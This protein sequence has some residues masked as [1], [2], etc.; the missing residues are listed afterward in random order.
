[1]RKHT[2]YIVKASVKIQKQKQLRWGSI[3]SGGGGG[4]QCC[5]NRASSH[6]VIIL[7]MLYQVNSINLLTSF[8]AN[9]QK[10]SDLRCVQK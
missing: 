7:Y 10:D 6:H 2:V 1:M 9:M 4:V 5:V 8:L 3:Y